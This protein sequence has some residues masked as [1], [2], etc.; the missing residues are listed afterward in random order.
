ML[1]KSFQPLSFV[2]EVT[3][4]LVRLWTKE[5]L[6]SVGC[7]SDQPTSRPAEQQKGTEKLNENK[8]VQLLEM[9]IA[10]S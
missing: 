7:Q 1:W 4:V 3:F 6:V 8:Y 2:L 5:G 9:T 10:I